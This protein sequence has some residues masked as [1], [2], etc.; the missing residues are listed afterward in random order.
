MVCGR[1]KKGNTYDVMSADYYYD[2]SIPFYNKFVANRVAN[3]IIAG[4]D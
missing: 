3:K 4:F 1:P 2:T